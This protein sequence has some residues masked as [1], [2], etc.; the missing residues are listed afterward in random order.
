MIC[1]TPP[2]RP[3][4]YT[5]ILTQIIITTILVSPFYASHETLNPFTINQQQLPER[6]LRDEET[7]R[8]D[9]DKV[10]HRVGFGAM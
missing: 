4:E 10:A 8:E 9:E 3:T 5:C 2:S 7:M 6:C 1:S